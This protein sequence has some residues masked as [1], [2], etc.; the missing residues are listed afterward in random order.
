MGSTW[1]AGTT[2][3]LYGVDR[4]CSLPV[5]KRL[6]V[7]VPRR[8]GT[9]PMGFVRLHRHKDIGSRIEAHTGYAPEWDRQPPIRY[10]QDGELSF[11]ERKA[12]G[13]DSVGKMEEGAHH[14]IILHQ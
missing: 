2:L 3:S 8:Y 11:K 10:L 4:V 5:T 9:L 6:V 7:T 13:F 14:L 1:Q 12:R